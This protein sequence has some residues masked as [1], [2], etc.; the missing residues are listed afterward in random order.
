MK[1]ETTQREAVVLHRLVRR[2]L[3]NKCDVCGRIISYADLESGKAIHNMKTPDSDVSYE[4]LETLCRDHCQPNTKHIHP[5]P[6]PK[7]DNNQ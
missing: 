6:T 5:E 7:D 2:D 4:T 1:T 3:W